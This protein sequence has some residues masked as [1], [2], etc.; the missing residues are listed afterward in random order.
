MLIR[1]NSVRFLSSSDDNSKSDNQKK[2]KI[3]DA[4]KNEAKSKAINRLNDLLGSMST[5]DSGKVLK[6]KVEIDKIGIAG[7]RK[8]VEKEAKN[9]EADTESD[10]DD[11]K[12]NNILDAARKVAN[13][14]GG[15]VKQTESELLSKLLSHSDQ[16]SQLSKTQ[17]SSMTLKYL[18]VNTYYITFV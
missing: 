16:I 15:D 6:S 4:D 17:K 14:L 18:L 7:R 11:E 12:P 2:P 10:S 9:R 1:Q 5:K 3:K 8:N 13:K